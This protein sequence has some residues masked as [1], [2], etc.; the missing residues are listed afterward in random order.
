MDD[1]VASLKSCLANSFAFYAKAHACHWNVTGSDFFQYHSLFETIYSE[2]YGSIDAFAELIRT[3]DAYA[4][5]TLGTL[6][7][8]SK[9]SSYTET[10]D[11]KSMIS[12]LLK[13]NDTVLLYLFSTYK[14]AE[15]AGEVGISNFIQDRIASHQ[16]HGWF[17]KASIK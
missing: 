8:L 2:V 11:S 13:D 14:V 6:A 7:E 3:L 17:L 5:P 4:P 15:A 1:L 16:K 12:S 9:L 10:G